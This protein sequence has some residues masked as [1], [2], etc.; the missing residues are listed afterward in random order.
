[1]FNNPHF[2]RDEV[3]V[4]HMKCVETV[5]LGN[6]ARSTPRTLKPLRASSIASGAPAL[7][8]PTIRTS[9]RVIFS[10]SGRYE[11]QLLSYHTVASGKEKDVRI[12]L[13]AGVV[14]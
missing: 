1:M 14:E 9:C 11:G 8:V 7:R 13:P 12:V 5:S 4:G 3:V 2:A 10:Y 6:C